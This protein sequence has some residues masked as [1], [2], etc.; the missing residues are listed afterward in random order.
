MG[1]IVK[2]NP[3]QFINVPIE[4]LQTDMFAGSCLPESL[5]KNIPELGDPMAEVGLP[6]LAIQNVLKIGKHIDQLDRGEGFSILLNDVSQFRLA[7]FN[8]WRTNS[9]NE[10]AKGMWLAGSPYENGINDG[11]FVT[12][13]ASVNGVRDSNIDVYSA[14][15][16]ELGVEELAPTYEGLLT[17]YM[18]QDEGYKYSRGADIITQTGATAFFFMEGRLPNSEI[19]DDP[20]YRLGLT[21]YYPIEAEAIPD[22]EIPEQTTSE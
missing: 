5:I 12:N 8:R 7:W 21:V 13:G 22:F 9:L 17:T 15:I 19:D 20:E 14:L 4:G 16:K 18:T 6:S 11:D 1:E 2:S 3:E 10:N